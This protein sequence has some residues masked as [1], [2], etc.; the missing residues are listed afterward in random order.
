[1]AKARSNSQ[2]PCTARA[3]GAMPAA[4][5]AAVTAAMT[6]GARIAATAAALAFIPAPLWAERGSSGHLDIAMWQAPTVLNPYRSAGTKDIDSANLV[7]EPLARHDENGQ[8]VPWLAETI[9]GLHNGDIAEDLMS[10]T[11]RLRPGLLW[12]DGTAVTAA[13]VAFTAAY[14]MA[15]GTGC[16]SA[17]FFA[18]IA[19]VEALDTH[20]LRIHFHEPQVQPLNAFIGPYTPVLQ[21]AQFAPCLPGHD[22]GLGAESARAPHDIARPDGTDAAPAVPGHFSD[23]CLAASRIPIGTG[24]FMVTDFQPDTRAEMRANPHFRD[25]DRPFFDTLTLHGGGEPEGVARAVLETGSMDYAWNLQLAWPVLATI[26]RGGRG[27][28]AVAF[29][30]LVERIEVNLTDPDPALPADIRST[31]A[32]PHPV[33]SDIRVREAL[34]LAIDRELLA[35]IGYGQAGR[36]TCD[37]VPAPAATATGS[38]DACLIPDPVRAGLLLDEAGWLPGADGIRRRDG[39]RL[40]LDFV[41]STSPVRQDFQNLIQQWWREIGVEARLRDVPPAIYFGNDP[42][43]PETLQRFHADLQLYANQ[44][45]GTD[46]Q[47]YLA[48]W[49]CGQEPRPETGWQGANIPRYCDPAY[50]ALHLRLTRMANPQE[51]ARV[52]RQLNDMLVQAFVI[53]PL[54]HRGR[55][56]AHAGSL[57]GVVMNTWDTEMWNI[58][59]WHRLER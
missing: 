18:D 42:D 53:L 1:M 50:D 46:P 3:P 37:L 21:A 22:T 40:A 32:A 34:S 36:A 54:V 23:A 52:A 51:R 5:T 12:S 26:A 13:D 45:S 25:P 44:F 48:T 57:G 10:I 29:G 49:R 16:A 4:V 9:P 8:L 41:T 58:A 6:G 55:V 56:S 2:R 39:Q 33:L 24:P 59:D 35:E 27:V 15:A 28:T 38:N 30:T 11:W 43:A 31:R 20:A 14:C 19:A 7:L 47:P 17:R